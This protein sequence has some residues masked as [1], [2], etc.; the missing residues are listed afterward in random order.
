V[1]IRLPEELRVLESPV[2]EQVQQTLNRGK[3]ECSL[4]FQRHGATSAEIELN[5]E[6]ANRLIGLSK[7]ASEIL[8][9]KH[10]MRPMELLRWPGVV[11]EKEPDL[12][13]INE[14]ARKL[15]DEAI[16]DLVQNRE[17]E[18]AR[19]KALIEQRCD[20]ME[21]IAIQTREYLPELRQYQRE[22]LQ[23]K[24]DALDVEVDHVRLEQE[25][26]I[27]AQKLDIDE[28]LDRLDAHIQEVRDVLGR[29]EPVGRRLD[30]LMQELN[31]EA[32]TLGSKS[33]AMETTQAS[34]ELKV[35]IEQMRE[36]VQNIE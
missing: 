19:L 1:N 3:L 22:R 26:V 17:R 5:R 35:L 32:N 7:E 11:Q 13:P 29:S 28:E 10:L 25:L 16:E 30:F 15:L 27:Q 12:A 36:Q 24:L 33:A 2:R 34:V 31:R 14:I 21:K 4:R 23:K 18:G 8:D 20:S 9:E 6:L